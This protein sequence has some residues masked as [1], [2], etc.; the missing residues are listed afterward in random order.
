MQLRIKLKGIVGVTIDDAL[1]M[2]SAFVDEYRVEYVPG[3]PELIHFRAVG[4][5]AVDVT[6]RNITVAVAQCLEAPVASGTDGTAAGVQGG[7]GGAGAWPTGGGR[8]E[9]CRGGLGGSR[10]EFLGGR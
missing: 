1:D 7:D 6:A 8:V 2:E 4:P 5:M 9:V 10:G 3:D